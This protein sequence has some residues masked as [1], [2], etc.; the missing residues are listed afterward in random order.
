MTFSDKA[1]CI[2]INLYTGVV[3]TLSPT[4]V[5]TT[6]PTKSQTAGLPTV[7]P[8]AQPTITPSPVPSMEPTTLDTTSVDVSFELSA[9]ADPTD[10]EKEALKATIA[11][12]IGI[13]VDN[14]KDYLVDSIS[15]RRRGLLSA[16]TWQIS[17]TVETSLAEAGVNSAPLL[18]NKIT[19]TLGS[20]AFQTAVATDVPGAVV[21]TSSITSTPVSPTHHPTNA[22]S[23][24][25]SAKPSLIPTRDLAG[26]GNSDETAAA[27]TTYLIIGVSVVALVTFSGGLCK[28]SLY[29]S[30]LF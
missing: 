30:L 11:N 27:S 17:F 15:N 19:T 8:S 26:G 16:Y 4:M 2:E 7:E 13:P 1:G 14:I 28:C 23:I 25:P 10:S 18:A 21:V 3:P 22:P 6:L 5:P 29:R 12:Q 20:S 9:D 24:S